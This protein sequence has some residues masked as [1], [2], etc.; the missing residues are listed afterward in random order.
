VDVDLVHVPDKVVAAFQP[1]LQQNACQLISITA[2]SHSHGAGCSQFRLPCAEL[3]CLTQLQL[4]GQALVFDGLG[5]N[6]TAAGASRMQLRSGMRL[7]S[8]PQLHLGPQAQPL[9]KLQQLKLA[10]CNLLSVEALLQFSVLTS[11]TSLQLKDISISSSSQ[12]EQVQH[13]LVLSNALCMLLAQLPQLEDVELSLDQLAGSSL[14]SVVQ[15]LSSM[16]RLRSVG[17]DILAKGTWTGDLLSVLPHGLTALSVSNWESK[18]QP[19]VF[20]QQMLQLSDLQELK[21]HHVVFH[22]GVLNVMT[23]LQ[24]L[25]LVTCTLLPHAAA[26][27]AGGDDGDDAAVDAANT[28]AVSALL[29]AVGR[30]TDLVSLTFRAG[31]LGS[32]EPWW[33]W[34]AVPAAAFSALTAS[35][36]LQEL[37]VESADELPLP[38]GAVQHA[39]P[40][41]RV[42][43][44]LTQLTLQGILSSVPEPIEG[45]G[46]RPGFMSAQHLRDVVAACPGLVELHICNAVASDDLTPLLQLPS[47]VAS[48]QLAGS[49][50]GDGAAAAVARL[51]QLKS[52]EWDSSDH[53]TDA[54]LEQLTALTGLTHLQMFCNYGLS[55]QV[56]DLEGPLEPDDCGSGTIT[57]P[58][59]RVYISDTGS[60]CLPIP[61]VGPQADMWGG[62]VCLQYVLCSLAG[63]SMRG[64]Y[65]PCCSCCRSPTVVRTLLLLT[66]SACCCCC[67][68]DVCCLHRIRLLC[69]SCCVTGWRRARSCGATGYSRSRSGCRSSWSRRGLRRSSRCQVCSSR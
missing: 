56:T 45:T 36:K 66:A 7:S 2:K 24:R 49:A 27:A 48:L 61:Q 40:A 8:G 28:A 43:P 18:Q 31:C 23:R 21:L 67:R 63:S 57:L 62:R 5:R 20:P 19:A 39:F 38:W 42:L 59:Q 9:P 1:W 12:Q 25:E 34:E 10:R 50:L 33:G 3:V 65:P 13:A 29:A 6:S 22:P 53:L 55:A 37:V 64:R 60:R 32:D 4:Q 51:T 69:G 41:G 58:E 17:I 26:A 52:L 30:M 14:S 16:S 11:L 35:S 44:H 68:F 47:S 15:Q 46:G 54:G